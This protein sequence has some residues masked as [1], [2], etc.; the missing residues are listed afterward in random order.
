[1]GVDVGLDIPQHGV[2]DPPSAADGPE[3]APDQFDV[4]QKVV[5]QRCRHIVQVVIV[6]A[7]YHEAP[8]WEASVVVEA[9]LGHREAGHGDP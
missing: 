5:G 9:N 7:K 4:V 1:M 3:R 6:L 2:V 8:P